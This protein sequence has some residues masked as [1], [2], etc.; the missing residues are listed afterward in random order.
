MH[1]ERRLHIA[2]L[3]YCLEGGG[4]Q[5]QTL[6]LARELVARGHVVDYLVVRAEGELA[7]HVPAGVA[8]VELLPTKNSFVRWKALDQVRALPPLVAYLK[9]RKPDALLAGG[10]HIN[11][12]S[13]VAHAAARSRARLVLRLTNHMSRSQGSRFFRGLSVA[14]AAKIYPRADAIVAVSEEVRRDFLRSTA[15][16]PE[17]TR[18]IR[19]PV[20][21]DAVQSLAEENPGHPW[22]E[23]G[24]PPVILGVG[25]LSPQKDFETLVRAFAIVRRQ[26]DVRLVIIGTGTQSA[27]ARKLRVLAAEL[28]VAD[29]TD[30]AGYAENPYAFIAKPKVFALSSAWEGC[31]NVVIEALYLGRAV[32]ATDCPGGVRE[33]IE[34]SGAGVLVPMKNPEAM[35]EA[36]LA[37]LDGRV[38]AIRRGTCPPGFDAATSTRQYLA[39]LS[40]A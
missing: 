35:A 27:Y 29:G 7:R 39:V 16:A 1:A 28:G 20:I 13:V 6:T 2:I 21:T 30:L 18:M 11:L 40:G 10:T 25:R 19:E 14:V 33:V 31:P 8:V 36:L 12:L 3:V 23:S 17:L 24:Q 4:V 32:V 5:R 22:L 34:G 9:T 37:A 38:P 15:V 26:R